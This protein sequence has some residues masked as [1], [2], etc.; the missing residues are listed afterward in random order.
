[1]YRPDQA[2]LV[3]LGVSLHRLMGQFSRPTISLRLHLN[4]FMMEIAQKDCQI[5]QKIPRFSHFDR[6]FE[7][8][9]SCPTQPTAEEAFLLRKWI[10]RRF[11][12]G[13]K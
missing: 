9:H 10:P 7:D 6:S 11:V 8:F 3:Q 4:A 2:A 12:V 13:S 1:M 5:I